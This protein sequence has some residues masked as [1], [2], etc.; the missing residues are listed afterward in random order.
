[1]N[2]IPDDRLESKERHEHLVYLCECPERY[3]FRCESGGLKNCNEWKE[4]RKMLGAYLH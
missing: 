2:E 4:L 3:G 1:M